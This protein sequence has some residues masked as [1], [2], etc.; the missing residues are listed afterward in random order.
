MQNL[1]ERIMTAA[2]SDGSGVVKFDI[3]KVFV[4][5]D[6]TAVLMQGDDIMYYADVDGDQLHVYGNSYD[7]RG[8]Y[9][10]TIPF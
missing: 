1:I 8:A 3:T 2:N 4:C 7:A 5:S 9:Q 6:A 10:G